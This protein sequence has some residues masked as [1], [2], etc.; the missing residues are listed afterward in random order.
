M[1]QSVKL[2]D[3]GPKILWIG[4]VRGLA[5]VGEEGSNGLAWHAGEGLKVHRWTYQPRLQTAWGQV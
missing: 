2:N 1:N 3:K 5:G 4:S